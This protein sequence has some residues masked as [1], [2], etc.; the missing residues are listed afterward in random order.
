MNRT[1]ESDMQ[2][3][4]FHGLPGSPM[5]VALFGKEVADRL[6]GLHLIDRCG[7]DAVPAG[8]DYFEHVARQLGDRFPGRPLRLIGFSLGAS[9]VLRSA[10]HLGSQVQRI[11]IVSAAAPLTLGDYL[12]TMA[13]AP[14]FRSALISPVLLRM[15]TWLQ[16][17]AVFALPGQFYSA[18]F[19]SARGEDA[20]LAR[21]P[22]FKSAMIAML[23]QCLGAGT[24][25]YRREIMLYTQQWEADL[26]RV[27]QPV[28]IHHG[29]E[30]NWAPAAMASDLAA[31]LPHCADLCLLDQMSHYSTLRAVLLTV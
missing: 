27:V 18:L 7:P 10:P 20:A 14:V 29:R 26:D 25:A 3:V 23:Q 5:E 22:A 9:A 13:G 17:K 30:D 31:R 16:S 11:D 24:A 1:F 19:G 21:D 28:W 4:Y 2:T 6:A 15:V 12:H 8:E